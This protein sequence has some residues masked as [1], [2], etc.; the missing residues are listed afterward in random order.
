MEPENEVRL[1]TTSFFGR[2]SER[3]FIFDIQIAWKFLKL[4]KNVN[5]IEWN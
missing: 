4:N 2:A 1:T 3:Y 5:K